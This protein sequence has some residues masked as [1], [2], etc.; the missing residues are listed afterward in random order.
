MKIIKRHIAFISKR[1]GLFAGALMLLAGCA[2]PA[3]QFLESGE[4]GAALV[5]FELTGD[6]EQGPFAGKFEDFYRFEFF[7]LTRAML[8]GVS[9]PRKK[10]RGAVVGIINED[11]VF[12]IWRLF[13][14]EPGEYFLP[15]IFE[16]AVVREETTSVSK[17][18][19]FLLP[20][21]ESDGPGNAHRINENTPNFTIEPKQIVYAGTFGARLTTEP[22]G[23]GSRRVLNVEKYYRFEVDHARSIVANSKFTQFPMQATDLFSRRPAALQKLE[24]PWNE[25]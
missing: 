11:S 18:T 3:T 2:A 24:R 22:Y 20:K 1:M 13:P 5:A 6:F 7:M 25:R 14:L 17:D 12:R 8:D 21:N 9:P 19:F 23:L 15:R 10:T 16:N 4:R